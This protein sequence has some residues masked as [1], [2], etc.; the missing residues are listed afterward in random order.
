AAS[1]TSRIVTG[2]VP[3][4]TVAVS[5]RGLY[6]VVYNAVEMS[7][8]ASLPPGGRD[9]CSK[10]T[11]RSIAASPSPPCRA[12]SSAGSPSRSAGLDG[13]IHSRTRITTPPEPQ[14]GQLTL[15]VPPA[16]WHLLRFVDR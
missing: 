14:E 6:N 5:R 8:H 9:A 12:A 2:R 15:V 1:A 13:G 16:P 11:P 3:A 10:R 7:P 4:G